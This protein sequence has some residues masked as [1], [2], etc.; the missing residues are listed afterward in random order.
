MNPHSILRLLGLCTVLSA[1]TNPSAPAGNDS[2]SAASA[3]SIVVAD[4]TPEAA[5]LLAFLNDAARPR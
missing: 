4:G 5:G 3:K 2:D 1:C